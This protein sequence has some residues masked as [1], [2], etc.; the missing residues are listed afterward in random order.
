MSQADLEISLF[1]RH[2][3]SYGLA[4]RFRHAAGGQDKSV[5]GSFVLDADEPRQRE[6]DPGA[7]G[8]Q[9]A[10]Q[11]FGSPDV[12]SFL[13]QALAAAA[14]AAEHD[15]RGFTADQQLVLRF[16]VHL[17]WEQWGRR[18]PK[19]FAE[20]FQFDAARP[21]QGHRWRAAAAKPWREVHDSQASER[22]AFELARG[23]DKP[24]A[25]AAAG[26]GLA[27]MIGASHALAGYNT[28]PQMADAFAS[29]E[30]YQMLAFF[31][32]LAGPDGGSRRATALHSQDLASY[33]MLT[34]GPGGAA[35]LAALLRQ[36][37]VFFQ[38]P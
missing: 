18:N 7:Y 12:R 17:F 26:L 25:C 13:D 14:L 31:D 21:W 28:A 10:A 9:L 5:T 38:R 6:H 11:L 29:S 22:A 23:L 15:P 36:A 8:E 37:V 2:A 34:A 24:A 4:L 19:P 20:H 35:R 30:R 16:E 33:A 32:L 3:E 1:Q 27:G